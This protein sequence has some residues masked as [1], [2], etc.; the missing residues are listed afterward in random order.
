MSVSW[1]IGRVS[2]GKLRGLVVSIYLLILLWDEWMSSRGYSIRRTKSEPFMK[3]GSDNE[4][5]QLSLLSLNAGIGLKGTWG[6][7]EY[8]NKTLSV[9]RKYPG[10]LCLLL[11]SISKTL[12]YSGTHY[13]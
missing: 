5:G 4:L 9:N 12:D 10:S 11:G 8:F 2:R 3:I 7:S 6:D 1:K 13:T